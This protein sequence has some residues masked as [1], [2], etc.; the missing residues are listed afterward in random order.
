MIIRSF[1]L[2]FNKKEAKQRFSIIIKDFPTLAQLKDLDTINQADTILVV[3]TTEPSC[4]FNTYKALSYLRK[5]KV[6]L[7]DKMLFAANNIDSRSAIT[8]EVLE[9][10]SKINILAKIEANIEAANIHLA[11][12]LPFDDKSLIITQDYVN[13][14]EG[15]FKLLF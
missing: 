13:L 15:I 2:R 7:F 1:P 8:K 5:H 11:K 6:G 3:V 12:V 9:E 4:I 14:A 10:K